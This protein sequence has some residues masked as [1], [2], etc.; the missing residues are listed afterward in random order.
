M[1]YVSLT[2]QTLEKIPQ[3]HVDQWGFHEHANQKWT[4][5]MSKEEFDRFLKESN[6]IVYKN[7]IKDYQDGHVNGYFSVL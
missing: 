4:A 3:L 6:S 5:T 1:I 2:N 7:S